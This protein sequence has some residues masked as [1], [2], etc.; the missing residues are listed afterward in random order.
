[1]KKRSLGRTGLAVSELSLGGLFV[2]SFGAEFEQSKQAVLRALEL[3]VNYIDTAPTYFDSEEVLGNALADTAT[4]FYLSTKIGGRVDPF[5]P[6]DPVCLRRSV[7]DSLT[8]LKRDRVDIL[9]VHEPDRPMLYDWWADSGYNG[10]VL[11]VLDQLKEEG[12][13][14]YTGLGSTTAYHIEPIIRTGRF[15]ILLTALN[16]SLLFREAAHCALPAAR[17]HN[18]GIVIGS[19]LQMGAYSPANEAE[20]RRGPAWMSPLRQAQFFALYDYA[21]EVDIALPELALRFV[22]SDP[23]ISCALM[24]ARSPGEV[25]Q[26]VAAVEQGP[27][28]DQVLTHLDEIAAMVPFRPCEEPFVLPLGRDYRGLGQAR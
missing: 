8:R 7:E 3:G 6:Q 17:E 9:M 19:P 27:L 4:P 11:E 12:I 5:L 14:R 13:V 21:H 18:M 28:S 15:D 23:R 26:N 20:V 10:P 24:G 25:E 2:S 22:L 16:Y 1:M